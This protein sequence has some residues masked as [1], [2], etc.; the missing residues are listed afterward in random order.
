MTTEAGG[1][2]RS[3]GSKGDSRSGSRRG[4]GDSAGSAKG[5][6]RSRRKLDPDRF[7]DLLAAER[8]R[9]LEELGYLEANYIGKT[10]RDATGSGS[11]YSMHPAD[12]GTDSIEQEKAYM[13][14]AVSGA[15]LEE[16]DEAL[17]R[18]SRG[19]YGICE[20]CC[21]EITEE[22]LEAVPYARYCLK[23]KSE[24]EGARGTLPK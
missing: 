10:P 20:R 17:D 12:M 3:A 2:G 1:R 15:A 16:I 9:V 13:I 4:A 21:E 23:C 6:A 14:G 22:R 8:R 11:A 5:G 7:R 24:L 18:L 19:N